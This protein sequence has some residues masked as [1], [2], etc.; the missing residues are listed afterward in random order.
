MTVDQAN[1]ALD[2]ALLVRVDAHQRKR[3]GNDHTTGGMSVHEYLAALR[4]VR[5]VEDELEPVRRAAG[6]TLSRAWESWKAREA[7]A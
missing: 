3:V 7:R 5:A 2:A 4:W 1:E 6:H